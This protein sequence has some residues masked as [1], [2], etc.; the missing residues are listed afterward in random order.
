M[1]RRTNLLNE[2]A[3][4]KRNPFVLCR[5]V[6]QRTRQLASGGWGGRVQEAIDTALEEL[7]NGKLQYEIREKVDPNR[8]PENEDVTF[9]MPT[10]RR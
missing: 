4:G 7:L 1:S 10:G 3:A 9:A 5:V 2:V 6:S 8:E